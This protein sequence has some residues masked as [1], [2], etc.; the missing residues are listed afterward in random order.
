MPGYKDY[1][2]ILGLKR[3]A[4]PE[5]IKQAY[6]AMAKKFHP[7][8][9]KAPDSHDRFI[10]ITEAY[11]IL[12]NRDLH[13]YYLSRDRTDNQEF[14]RAQYERAREAAQEAARRYA[15]MKFEKFKQEQEAFKK[16]GWHDL[17]LTLRYFI[18]VLVFPLI[19]IFIVLP[20]ISEEVSEHPTGY[21][22]FWI[23]ALMLMFFVINNWKNY[24][25]IDSFYYHLSDLGKLRD[26]FFHHSGQ[27]CY[28]CPGQKAMAFSYKVSLFR[29]KNIRVQ[30]FGAIDGKRSGIN[31]DY[32]IIRIPRSRKAFIVHSLAS[33]IKIS[34]L[35]LCLI[36]VPQIPFSRLSLPIGLVLGGLLSGFFL[37]ISG[38]KPKSSYL[39]SY[40]MLIKILVW[41]LL[42][43]FLDSYAFIF[44]FFDPMLEALLRFLSNERL[45]IPLVKQYPQLDHLFRNQYQLY[46]ELP[47]LSVMNP[48]LKWLL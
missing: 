9:N 11:E 21:I 41:T 42:I 7:D 10:E 48:L 1:H 29:I 24:F 8:I 38:T 20:L 22:I 32:K 4:K 33:L 47:V 44:L 39:L 5:D 18:R 16:S 26:G 28:Y 45:F 15:R 27:E 31:R 46:M 6:R 14:A 34:V 25:R 19:G 23:I 40:G 2:K 36:Y 17:I 3:D 35:L 13:A 37:A 43:W 30:N 12:M